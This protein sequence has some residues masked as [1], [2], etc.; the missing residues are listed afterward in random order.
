MWYHNNIIC[1]VSIIYMYIA[2][3]YEETYL[4]KVDFTKQNH[5]V[6][7]L[8]DAVLSH[9]TQIDF[10]LCTIINASDQSDIRSHMYATQDH[11][12]YKKTGL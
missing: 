12:Y 10:Y 9:E 2:Q 7:M 1:I 6:C 11:A 5:K 8:H 3:H 4:V